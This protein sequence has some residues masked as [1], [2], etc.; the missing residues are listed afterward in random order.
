MRNLRE[1][2]REED[3]LAALILAQVRTK[4]IRCS[5]PP[6]PLVAKV[7]VARVKRQE[8]EIGEMP[9]GTCLLPITLS[10]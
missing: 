6:I 9:F 8:I 5:K 7:I 1:K 2:D 4:C 3:T 10:N